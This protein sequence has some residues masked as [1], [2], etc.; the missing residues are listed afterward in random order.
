MDEA[1]LYK[2]TQQTAVNKR[3][4]DGL[5][6]MV[7]ELQA[8]VKELEISLQATRN[9]LAMTQADLAN[10]KQLTAHVMGRGMGSTTE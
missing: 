7:Q 1:E 9:N 5:L 4:I 2:S 3:N 6:I 10:T 8:K